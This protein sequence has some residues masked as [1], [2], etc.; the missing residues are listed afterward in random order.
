GK[1]LSKGETV[2]CAV[3]GGADSVVLLHILL[4]L[5]EE[6]GLRLIVAHMDHG[7]R[8]EESRRD[9]DFVRDLARR[10]GLEFTSRLLE[11]GELK[12]LGGSPQEAAR[13]KR[14]AFFEETAAKYRAQKVA[15]GHTSDDQ[16]ETVIMRLLKGS[17]LSGLSGIPPVRG[18]FVR[19]LI[20]TSRAAIEEY[21]REHGIA[22]VTDSTNLTV[23]YLRNRV[24]L[25][26][27]P[28]LEKEYNPSIKETLAR[29]AVLLS[30]DD[31]FIEKAAIK[32]FKAALIEQKDNAIVLDRAELKRIH[33]A[34]SA[35]VFLASVR[36][37]GVEGELGS[38]HVDAF[39]EIMDS[40]RPNA[41]ISLPDGARAR[42]EYG[43]MIVES[44]S[45]NEAA[46]FEQA[47]NVP[48]VTLME[49]IGTIEAKL[50]K[51]P[52]KFIGGANTAWFD[53]DALIEAGQLGVNEMAEEMQVHLHRRQSSFGREEEDPGGDRGR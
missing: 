12:G 43:R 10:Y 47:I 51:P 26:L 19:P 9:H 14:Y 4:E 42:R 27:L 15:L 44:N 1:M 32:A 11:K 38:L 33:R 22:F 25:E 41:F 35:R 5:K 49:G 30:N 37:L 34:L 46:L 23:K 50:V 31:D 40:E 29:T 24:R 28:R 13:I 39:F 36:S 18:I 45:P 8:A 20:Q 52:K 6:L 2:I 53:Y 7:L 3:S 16:A 17:S 21:A 48:G